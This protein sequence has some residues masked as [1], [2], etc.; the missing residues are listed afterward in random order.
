M[1]FAWFWE[2]WT[3]TR[4]Y[5]GNSIAAW[6]SWL[7]REKPRRAKMVQ[8]F[9]LWQWWTWWQWVIWGNSVSAWWGGWWSWAQTIVNIPAFMLPNRLYISCWCATSW[10]WIASYVSIKPST[11]WNLV[12]AVAW[13]WWQWGNGTAW[14]WGLAWASWTAWTA[15]SMCFWRPWDQVLWGVS[16]QAWWT[17]VSTASIAFP[18]TWLRVSGWVGWWG[19]PAAA[20]VWTNWGS[21]NY[22]STTFFSNPPLAIWWTSA[23]NPPEN[24]INWTIF[25]E[26]WIL[27]T[28]GGWWGSTHWSATGAWLVQ[29]QWWK[30]AY[31]CG[32]WWN[33]WALTGSTSAAQ[34]QW[35]QWFCLISVW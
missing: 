12:V 18:T 29:S 9:L 35:W 2:N 1:D 30:W 16:W 25:Q 20:T 14:T 27:F 33:G 23:T 32:S 11:V 5:I 19:L 21:V 22:L 28:W 6:S 8:I 31:W 26:A 17:S 4:S 7:I 24:G 10:A 15:A 13:W 34:V 3:Q